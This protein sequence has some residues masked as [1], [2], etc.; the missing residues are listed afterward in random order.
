MN[1]P[2]VALPDPVPPHEPLL[3]PADYSDYLLHG[4]SEILFV[5]R[6]LMASTDR[7]TAYFNEGQ[8]FLLSAIIA[9]DDDGVTL[10]Y[11]STQEMNEKALKADKMFCITRHEKVRV[12]FLLRGL[13][14]IDHQGRPAFR[15]ALPDS[16]LRLQRREYYRLTTP[17]I[18]P[19]RCQIPLASAD[20]TSST[21][22]VNIVDI[23]GGGVAI[24]VPP[25]E[26]PFETGMRFA[27][28]KIDLPEVGTLVVTLQ[29][30]SIFDV[31][32]RSGAHVKRA[33]CQFVKLP[34]PML[35]L[36]QRYII[37]VERERKARESGIA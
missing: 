30:R 36:V 33:G 7:I 19:L 17:I 14:R 11:G 24:V 26:V 20:G 18:N 2:T 6:G 21:F 5:L 31:T 3:E 34:G 32:L 10:D 12:Q 37:K 28:C 23:S 13:K 29:V 16:V 22:T 15:A 25:P 8:D 4:T 27:N 1:D 9:V 35:T